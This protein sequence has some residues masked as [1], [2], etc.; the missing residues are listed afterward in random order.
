MAVNFNGNVDRTGNAVSKGLKIP[1]KDRLGTQTCFERSFC[2][3]SNLCSIEIYILK[4]SLPCLR[5]V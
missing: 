1:Q 2:I 5:F 3:V 4:C